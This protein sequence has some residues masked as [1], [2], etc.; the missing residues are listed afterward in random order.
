MYPEDH[1]HTLDYYRNYLLGN[2]DL[3]IYKYVHILVLKD[4]STIFN[5]RSKTLVVY[6]IL[7]GFGQ[8]PWDLFAYTNLY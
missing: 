3:S 2:L 4:L 5:V 6:M 1:T 7:F 8:Y